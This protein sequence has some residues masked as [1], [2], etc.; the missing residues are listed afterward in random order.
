M[1]ITVKRISRTIK[2]EVINRNIVV[3]RPINNVQVNQVGRRGPTGATG[4]TGPQGPA[5][6]PASN[7]VTSVNGQQGVVVLDAADVGAD[8]SGAAAAALVSANDYTD[9]EIAGIDTGVLTVTAGTNV[10]ITGTATNPV[11][12]ATPGGG[13]VDSVNGQTGVVVLDQDDV[14]D[15][16][17]NK[18]YSQ[19]E[20]TKLAGI[21]TAADVT[22]ATNVAAAGAT[23]D[24]DTSLAGNGYFLDEDNMA[25]DSATKVP[26]Q[27]SV[28]AYVDNTAIGTG[29]VDGPASATDTAIAVF[30]GTT[31][32][33]IKNSAATINATGGLTVTSSTSPVLDM[34]RSATTNAAILVR[35]TVGSNYFGTSGTTADFGI[36]GNSNLANDSYLYVTVANRYIGLNGVTSPTAQLSLPSSAAAAG[37]IAFG[38]DTNLYRSAANV[39]TTDDTLT[40]GTPGTS[41]GSVVTIDGS[42][43]LTNKTL[44]TPTISAT[45]FTNAQHAHAAANSGGQIPIANTTGTLT[46]AR[47][48]TGRTTGTTAYGLIAAGTTATGVQQTISPGTSGHFL[49][50]AG[51]SALA[52]F[53]AITQSDVTNLVSD[54]ALKAPL[55]SPTFTGTVVLPSSQIVTSAVLNTG[56][57]GTAVDNDATLAANS[58]T[59]L[60][61]QQAVKAYADKKGA[62]DYEVFTSSGTWTKPSGATVVE[63][64]TIGAGGGGGK[65]AAGAEGTNR[66]GGGGGAGGGIVIGQFDATALTGTV[67][68]TVG[69]GG[70]GDT[71]GNALAQGAAGGASSFGSYIAAG[72]GGGGSAGAFFL[73]AIGGSPGATS[74]IAGA[75]AG[76]TGTT[77]GFMPGGNP[78]H[79]GGG[80]GGAARTSANSYDASSA[81]GNSSAGSGGT[82]GGGTVGVAGGAGAN[83]TGTN[84]GAGGGGGSP[85]AAGGAGGTNG[86][87]GGGGGAAI[88]PA[89]GGNGGNGGAGVVI[90]ITYG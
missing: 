45:G 40:V 33:L 1:N 5:G 47:G 67:S 57:S 15:G 78:G 8:T 38:T 36:G 37:G 51:A 19:T 6:D 74:L 44:T 87:G 7:L 89:T 31:G 46:V 58:A 25:S 27:Q 17:T 84:G 18:Q 2:V 35:N 70:A 24:T 11:I 81:G 86:G 60:A 34:Y 29:D 73:G 76:G 64:F 65:G 55:A 69:A 39:L 9:Q 68:V 10:S 26:S 75:G 85:T 80:A 28:K 12:N 66:H 43:T 52:S 49:K 77:L 32:K 62:L 83:G 79:T 48:G 14:L 63:V 13:A 54:L 22:D 61:T 71:S 42:Q 41:A 72:G 59:L 50:S 21:E 16:T 3:K 23:M 30:D 4:A 82:A 88:S 56:V 53:A 90:V 20:K